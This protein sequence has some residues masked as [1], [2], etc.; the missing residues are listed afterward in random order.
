MQKPTMSPFNPNRHTLYKQM[1]KGRVRWHHHLII[2]IK[3]RLLSRVTLWSGSDDD[4]TEGSNRRVKFQVIELDANTPLD[5]I[6]DE[7]VFN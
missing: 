3:T 5:V 6:I 7:L 4:A 1:K 2:I